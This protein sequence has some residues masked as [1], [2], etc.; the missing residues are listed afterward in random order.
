MFKKLDFLEKWNC[1]SC[2]SL[3]QINVFKR[4]NFLSHLSLSQE[5]TQYLI[6]L[7]LS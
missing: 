4:E 5:V 2:D 1:F 7:Y 3:K 6:C